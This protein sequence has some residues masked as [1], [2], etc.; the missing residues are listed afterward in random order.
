NYYWRDHLRVH[1]PIV[2]T[3]DV[4][5]ECDHETVHMGSGEAWVFDTWRPHRVVNPAGEPRVHL[6]VDTVGSAAL[7]D[8][9]DAPERPVRD[10]PVASDVDV[11]VVTER[12]N[13]PIVMTPWEFHDALDAIVGELDDVDATRADELWHALRPYVRAWREA[14]A[15]FGPGPDGWDTFV[16]L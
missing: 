14:W 9:I 4:T 2:T 10:V 1:F 3:P 15:R 12:M 11:T 5:F 7:W 8:L 13:H 16:A 6:V